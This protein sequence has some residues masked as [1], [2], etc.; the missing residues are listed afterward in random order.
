[1]DRDS[2]DK[3]RDQGTSEGDTDLHQLNPG[4]VRAVLDALPVVLWSVTADGII[5][6]SEGNGL[7]GLGVSPG[8]LVGAS[9]FDVYADFPEAMEAIRRGL[10]GEE[11]S[12]DTEVA[13]RI[14]ENRYIPQRDA[15]GNVV[16]LMGLSFDA[17]ERRQAQA[18]QAGLQAQLLHAQKL[19]GLGVLAGGI[20]H[21]FN[22]ILVG[23][24]GH[25]GL[26][27]D[28][29][30][31]EQEINHAD[32]I[33][34]GAK[35]AAD[36]SRQMLAYSGRGQRV[37][38]P[39]DM[40]ELISDITSLLDV[41]IPKSTTVTHEFATGLPA[42]QVDVTQ[43]R[44][45]AMNLITNA[46]DAIGE[47][48]GS[49][50]VSTGGLSKS[51]LGDTRDYRGGALIADSYVYFEVQDDG[52]GMDEITAQN[53]FDPFFSTKEA[54]RGLG[55]AAVLG[56]VR[57]HNGAILVTSKPG[58]GTTFRVVIPAVATAPQTIDSVISAPISVSGSGRTVLVVDDDDHVRQIVERL[59]RDADYGVLSAANGD[60]AVTLYEE[61]AAE[62]DLVLVDMTMPGMNGLETLTELR[63]RAPDA[64]VIL[65]S[66][67]SDSSAEAVEQAGFSEF[68]A[69]PYQPAELYRVLAKVLELD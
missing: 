9:V 47:S 40:S 28:R 60:E 19:E 2:Q 18:A 59:L 33:I 39:I 13:D 48:G 30:D 32:E 5:T 67:Y 45:V 44:Q 66:G 11:F 16:A 41:A 62:I 35:R 3:Q 7:R 15:Q 34:H 51:E 21:D 25:A 31:D 68:L 56:I 20:A 49:I 27:K 24:L 37:T 54:G 69:K 64:K 8:Q 6:V 57:S 43:L 36:L 58:I 38:R 14:W 17:T 46:S 65:T 22:N 53:L 4:H 55:L 1:M 23:I 10:D 12:M 63:K 26:L 61:N 52:Q 42:V 50:R 29:L